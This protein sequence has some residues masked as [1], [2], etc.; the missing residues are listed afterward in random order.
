MTN[1]EKFKE[2]YDKKVY[3]SFTAEYK[4]IIGKSISKVIPT[5]PETLFKKILSIIIKGSDQEGK[6]SFL[7]GDLIKF[8]KLNIF[9]EKFDKDTEIE[10]RFKKPHIKK[11]YEFQ[12]YNFKFKKLKDNSTKLTYSHSVK[13]PTTITGFNGKLGT[14]KFKN[15]V[16]KESLKM[17]EKLYKIFPSKNSN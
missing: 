16:K 13:L 5:D 17:F 12:I 8:E 11:G 14:I 3:V 1:Y 9:I 7:I 10:Y 4:R 2:E 6:E 15:D